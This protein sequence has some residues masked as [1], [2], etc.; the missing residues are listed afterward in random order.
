MSVNITTVSSS[1]HLIAFSFCSSRTFFLKDTHMHI[2]HKFGGR[3]VRNKEILGM[4]SRIF[5]PLPAPLNYKAKRL[6]N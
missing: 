5:L 6:S 3:V 4:K 1:D 2:V